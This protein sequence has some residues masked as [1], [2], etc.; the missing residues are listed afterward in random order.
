MENIFDLASQCLHYP[1]IEEKLA[2]TQHA[3]ELQQENRLDFTSKT[4]PIAISA[5]KFPKAPEL[6]D[7]KSMPRRSFAAQEGVTA[8]FHAIAHIEFVAIYL[9][10]DM[11]YRFRGMPQAF[12]RDWLHVATEEALHF[13][14]IRHFLNQ[15][16]V[17]Y[18]DLPAHQGLWQRAEDT[19]DDFL[20]RLALVPRGMEARGLDVTPAMIEKCRAIGE[21]QGQSILQRIL[22][23][24]V[25]HVRIG[26]HWFQYQC[27]Q[28]QVD[29]EQTYQ[30]LILSY[31]K[32][33]PKGPF[34]QKLRLQAGFSKAELHWLEN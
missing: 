1:D 16:G 33:K 23:D 31:L 22:E 24:E 25:G 20:A 17:D 4:E 2:I 5:T 26:S 15:R 7:P 18:G 3:G 14:L 29:I 6:R 12:Y 30:D 28:Q 32:G 10:W 34:N 27:Q 13:S 9:A 11:I 21:R 19:A 8:L